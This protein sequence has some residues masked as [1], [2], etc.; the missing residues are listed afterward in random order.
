MKDKF[1]KVIATGLIALMISNF[2][3]CDIANP[4]GTGTN[5]DDT[6]NPTGTSSNLQGE[7]LNGSV[8]STIKND[9]VMTYNQ[10]PISYAIKHQA[11]PLTFLQDEGIVYKDE[12]DEWQVKGTQPTNMYSP[13]ESYAY[14]DNNT[15]AND[16]YLFVQY[17]NN[18]LGQNESNP[19][20]VV[21]TWQLK[22][23]L[24]DDDYETFLKLNGDYR[25]RFFIQEMDKQYEPEVISKSVIAHDQLVLGS[26]TKG[27]HWTKQEFPYV[28][29]T[30][31]DYENRIITYGALANGELRYYD[32]DMSKTN[33]WQLAISK[34]G[35]TE[36][37][38]E[39]SI[40]IRT[41][42]TILG[43]CLTRFAVNNRYSE[44]TID[45]A[46]EAYKNSDRRQELSYINLI[47]DHKNF[48]IE[49]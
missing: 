33:A 34:H 49:Q 41:K 2:T 5:V 20:I 39:D 40:D 16:V 8:W 47:G 11:I 23:T 18:D 25:I 12:F 35:L 27:E 36:Q 38:R 14:V 30:N 37:E 1:N 19:D 31:V 4:F 9:S 26:Y 32:L 22:Y 44:Y 24:D 43:T 7:T 13:F 15:K 10:F 17:A 45:Q 3:A 46:K 29:V 6:T 28:F 48:G 42:S 21:A